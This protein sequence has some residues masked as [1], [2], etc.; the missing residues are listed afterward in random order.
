[1]HPQ[2][3]ESGGAGDAKALSDITQATDDLLFGDVDKQSLGSKEDGD[4][5]GPKRTKYVHILP[6]SHTDL[7]WLGTIDDYFQG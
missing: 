3:T 1:M 6:H 5:S 4:K 2:T 7:G